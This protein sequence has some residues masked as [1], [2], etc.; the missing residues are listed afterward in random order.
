V[1]QTG[2]N[3]NGLPSLL[4]ESTRC[5]LNLTG[6]E[7]ARQYVEYMENLEMN[8]EGREMYTSVFEREC[9]AEGMSEGIE[10][11]KREMAGN[12]LA[13]GVP[14]DIIAHASGMSVSEIRSMLDAARRWEDK[15]SVLLAVNYLLD[16]AGEEDAKE[17]VKYMENLEMDKEDREMYTSVFER[18]YKAE[19]M[20]EGV[21]KGRREKALEMAR[22]LLT[23]GV[24]PE[25]IAK[26][27]GLSAA[28]IRS[29]MN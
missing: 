2:G 7:Y 15:K 4:F 6:E 9:K 28:E 19:G 22:N 8:M 29:L 12:L 26:A 14:P 25:V 1:L 10:K 17:Y 20:S 16:L 18:V 24:S 13:R 5:L 21:E 3:I 27:S 23:D 11:G